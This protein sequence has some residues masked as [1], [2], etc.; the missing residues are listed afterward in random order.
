MLQSSTQA[1]DVV[2]F[3]LLFL[4]G[5]AELTINIAKVAYVGL[6]F[7]WL[8]SIFLLTLTFS[9][10]RCGIRRCQ[11]A[12]WSFSLRTLL[13]ITTIAALILGT[14]GTIIAATR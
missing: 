11:Q 7:T 5:L 13:L 10:V 1:R 2:F 9:S 14:I 8:T 4:Y 3:G 6:A 12:R